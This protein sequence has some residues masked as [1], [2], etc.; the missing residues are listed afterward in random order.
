MPVVGPPRGVTY[1]RI[2]VIYH[3]EQVFD[4][5]SY[6]AP[7]TNRTDINT[8]TPQEL[9]ARALCRHYLDGGLSIDQL[10]GVLLL[11]TS[12]EFR[13]RLDGLQPGAKRSKQIT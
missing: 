10:V 9:A 11:F 2:Y 6:K 7:F 12:D 3:V 13:A 4:L 5:K 8:M 1:H